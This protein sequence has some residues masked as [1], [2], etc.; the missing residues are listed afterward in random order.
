MKRKGPFPANASITVDTPPKTKGGMGSRL[1]FTGE[2]MNRLMGLWVNGELWRI[3]ET[4]RGTLVL[5]DAKEK[6][7]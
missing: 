7:Q 6:H 2:E 5:D 3:K 1:L 4:W